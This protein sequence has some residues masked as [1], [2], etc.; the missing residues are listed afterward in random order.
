MEIVVVDNLK[1]ETIDGLSLYNKVNK[2]LQNKDSKSLIIILNEYLNK[3]PDINKVNGLSVQE[4]INYL[5]ADVL[6]IENMLDIKDLEYFHKIF[7]RN[8]TVEVKFSSLVENDFDYSI[9]A[10]YFIQKIEKIFE[11]KNIDS[12]A[13]NLLNKI[14]NKNLSYKNKKNKE[15][16]KIINE[17]IHLF[18]GLIQFLKEPLNLKKLL[19]KKFLNINIEINEKEKRSFFKEY[20]RR[21]VRFTSK[22]YFSIGDSIYILKED[23]NGSEI[24]EYEL[25]EKNNRIYSNYIETAYIFEGDTPSTSITLRKEF[26]KKYK[27]AK[28]IFTGGENHSSFK[29]GNINLHFF[30]NKEDVLEKIK[31]KNNK[32]LKA[33]S[34]FFNEPLEQEISDIIIS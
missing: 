4:A 28:I 13:K 31:E 24:K 23:L 5:I 26:S 17:N 19:F 8:S 9:I 11:I 3:F 1:Q 34:D 27:K 7:F 20:L 15:R 29:E 16:N 32:R 18:E 2:D 30:L 33:F 25:I 6:Q 10:D 14:N 22:D 12:L 21:E